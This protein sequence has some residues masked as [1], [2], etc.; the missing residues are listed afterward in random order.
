[1]AAK[2][3][4]PTSISGDLTGWLRSVKPKSYLFI[5]AR[6]IS[7]KDLEQVIRKAQHAELASD[8]VGV[9]AFRAESADQPTR[10]SRALVPSNL[11]LGRV[12]FRA[13]QELTAIKKARPG[14]I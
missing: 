14:D 10:Y 12:L 9:Y 2:G 7:D 3:E 5:A 11:E 13:C 6:V 4:A 8:A 1:M